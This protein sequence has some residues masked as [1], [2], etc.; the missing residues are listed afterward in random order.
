MDTHSGDDRADKEQDQPGSSFLF[1]TSR[2]SRI[3]DVR[4]EG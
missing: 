2:S 1:S 3:R 4:A